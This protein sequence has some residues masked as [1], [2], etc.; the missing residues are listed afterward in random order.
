MSDF[1]VIPQP[2]I[3]TVSATLQAALLDDRYNSL[4]SA[5]AYI[6]TSG[7]QEL[8]QVL[9]TSSLRR[10]WL[11]SFDWCRSD[12]A[13]LSALQQQRG[14]SVRVHDGKQVVVRR[15]CTPNTPF[16][17]KKFLFTGPEHALLVSGSANMSR[18]G[19]R[20]GV[21]FDTAIAVTGRGKKTLTA[22]K[23]IDATRNWFDAEWSRAGR[24]AGLAAGYQVEYTRRP[25]ASVVLEFGDTS[26]FVRRGFTAEQL[27]QIS[28]AETMWIEA[29]N[30]TAQTSATPGHQLMM[31]PLT[32]VFFGFAPLQVP[33][34]TSLGSV[35]IYFDGLLNTGRSLEFAHNSMDR[36][37][38]PTSTAAG[39][40][41]YD[42]K[43]LKFTKFALNGQVAF[44]LAVIG[45]REQNS[46]TR[47]SRRL[48]LR[49]VMPGGRTFGFI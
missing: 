11:T 4:R 16:H 15:G 47:T 49:F 25:P 40:A 46:L 45:Q 8:Q 42:G 43:V 36:L 33:R 41:R 9:S 22:W 32:R 28:R 19:L 20:Q 13:A 17:P 14:S 1:E 6:T 7:V 44:E 30:L 34:M 26:A 10:S 3:S 31:R 24:F 38:L 2:A 5:V 21:E 27:A 39:T 35:A 29:G 18:N 23:R 12:P 48:G 37:N